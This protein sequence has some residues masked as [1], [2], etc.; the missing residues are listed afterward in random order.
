MSPAMTMDGQPR[1]L[2]PA[3]TP[4]SRAMTVGRV[5]LAAPLRQIAAPGSLRNDL[6]GWIRTCRV[7][8]RD[9]SHSEASLN[10]GPR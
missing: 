7:G 3:A 4:T 6:P 8:N 9:W 10:A 1:A 2:K 5:A